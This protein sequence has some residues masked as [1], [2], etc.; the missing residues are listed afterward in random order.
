MSGL[1][2]WFSGTFLGTSPTLTSAQNN[3]GQIGSFASGT[4]MSNT[5]AGSNWMQSILNGNFSQALAPEISA[6]QGQNAQQKKQLAEFGSR[7]GGTASAA[8]NIDAQGRSN[9]I[10]LEGGLQSGA[11]SNLLSSGTSLLGTGLS[12]F[13]QQA[14]IAN[15]QM[16]NWAD[17]IF[18]KAATT[19]AGYGVAAAL[20]A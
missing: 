19:G 15:Q 9:L 2:N 20:T 4:G 11:A 6:Q 14:N 7:S 12:A 10:N 5:T 17:S 18:G 1:S 13:G 3:S 16:Q 8:A